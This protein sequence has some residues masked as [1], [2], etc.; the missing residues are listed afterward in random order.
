MKER[1][2]VFIVTGKRGE[3]KTSFLSGLTN[4]FTEMNLVPEGILA[5][6]SHGKDMPDRYT[7]KHIQ[8]GRMIPLCSR[9]Q[10]RGWQEAGPFYFNPQALEAGNRIL[11][12]P[13]IKN[14]DL[15]ILDEVGKFELEGRIWAE[16]LTWLL[17]NVSCPLIIAVREAF[18]ERVVRHWNLSAVEIVHISKTTPL[19]ISGEIVKRIKINKP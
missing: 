7:L 13:G 4:R 1:P 15:I 12:H 19:N 18:V 10:V 11:T 3:G 16:S 17:H 5:L 6:T 2:L 9:I 14:N 8:S